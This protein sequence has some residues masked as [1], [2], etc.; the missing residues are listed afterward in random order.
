MKPIDFRNATFAEIQSTVTGQRQ[1]VYQALRSHGPCTTRE[2]AE[3][4]G[5][6]ILSVRPRVTELVE[7]FL[8]EC[9]GGVRGREGV[10]RALSWAEGQ[11]LYNR[12]KHAAQD[13]E[14]MLMPMA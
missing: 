8:V 2:L 13:A 5:W 11:A 4:M 3:R 1:D 6:D 14:Q 9:V 12:T 10:Y 7:L